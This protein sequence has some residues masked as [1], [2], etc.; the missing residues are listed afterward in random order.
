MAA[1]KKVKKAQLKEGKEKKS[2]HMKKLEKALVYAQDEKKQK[3][4]G[5]ELAEK[6]AITDAKNLIVQKEKAIKQMKKEE[7]EST[8]A[9]NAKAI[10]AKET[11]TKAK[12]QHIK[13]RE[14][15]IKLVVMKGT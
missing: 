4:T 2:A 13:S 12:E 5:K 1:E 11:A 15:K 6:T 9:A 10:A 8:M 7:E 14:Q 3:I